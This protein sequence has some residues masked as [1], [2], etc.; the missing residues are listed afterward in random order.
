MRIYLVRHGE[1][2]ANADFK[3][4]SKS[5]S[6]FTE[7]GKKQCKNI[8]DKLLSKDIKVIY[9]SPLKRCLSQADI[10]ASQKKIIPITTNY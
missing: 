5:N 9:T 10:L 7:D 2:K 1:T 8:I 3:Y 6:P 4:L